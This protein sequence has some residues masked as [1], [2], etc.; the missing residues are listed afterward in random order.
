MFIWSEESIEWYRRASETSRYFD[1]VAKELSPYI[2]SG[3]SVGEIG[4]GPGYLSAA[5][6]H[7]AGKI[8]AV[9]LDGRVLDVLRQRLKTLKIKNVEVLHGDWKGLSTVWDTVIACNLG[10]MPGDIP[11]LLDRGAKQLILIRRVSRKGEKR[12]AVCRIRDYLSAHDFSFHLFQR[13]IDFGQP[14]DSADQA[15]RYFSH[16]GTPEKEIADVLNQPPLSAGYPNY[17]PIMTSTTFF[18]I[19]KQG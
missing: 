19:Q 10:E 2:S 11:G 12:E 18:I 5:A 1:T 17:Y 16:Y 13:N 6:S 7:L 14:F 15:Y 8:T 9:D 4:S 3:E